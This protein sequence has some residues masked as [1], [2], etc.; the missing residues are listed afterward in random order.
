MF[1]ISC[2]IKATLFTLV[3]KALQGL[4]PPT[5]PGSSPATCPLG[6]PTAATVAHTKFIPIWRFCMRCF[7]CMKYLGLRSSPVTFHPLTQLHLKYHLLREIFL[8]HAVFSRPSFPTDHSL[9]HHPVL[10]PM[11]H[12]F[13]YCPSPLMGNI[14]SMRAGSVLGPIITRVLG[15]DLLNKCLNMAQILENPQHLRSALKSWEPEKSF[16]YF[17]HQLKTFY[18]TLVP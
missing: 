16:F 9:S 3:Y 18:T 15:K 6:E 12:D 17:L 2:R 4:A 1:S 11:W 14:N 7:L 8:V 13:I 10:Y 5:S